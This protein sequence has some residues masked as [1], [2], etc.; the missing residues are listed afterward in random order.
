ML[1]LKLEILVRKLSQEIDEKLKKYDF[2]IKD[3]TFDKKDDNIL[4]IKITKN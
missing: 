4:K 3:I 1:N 2:K